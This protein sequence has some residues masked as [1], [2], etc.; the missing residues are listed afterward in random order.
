MVA[1]MS[2]GVDVLSICVL[3]PLRKIERTLQRNPVDLG[4]AS[5]PDLAK[6]LETHVSSPFRHRLVLRREWMDLLSMPNSQEQMDPAHEIPLGTKHAKS[7][8]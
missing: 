7:E 6:G 4:S 3:N 5:I 8:P 1:V 2:N